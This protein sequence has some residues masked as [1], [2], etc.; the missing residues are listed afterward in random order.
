MV[1]RLFPA[2][3]SGDG[4]VQVFLSLGLP[5]EV[6]KASGSQ[7]GIKWPVL[8]TGFTRYDASYFLLLS[9]P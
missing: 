1:Q 9:V 6:L 4:D 5:D 2:F 8:R 7:A 3:S